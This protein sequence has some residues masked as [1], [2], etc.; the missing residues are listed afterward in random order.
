MFLGQILVFSHVKYAGAVAQWWKT[1]IIFMKPW[2][3][4]PSLQK[5]DRQIDSYC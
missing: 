3:Q 1:C 4:S 5:L 2:F